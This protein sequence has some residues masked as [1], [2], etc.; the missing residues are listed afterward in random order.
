MPQHTVHICCPTPGH[1]R[2]AF[3]DDDAGAFGAERDNIADFEPGIDLIDLER[4]DAKQAFPFF[5]DQDFRWIGAASFTAQGQLRF[6]A[7]G[8]DRF[9]QGNVDRDHTPEFTILLSS[10]DV[11]PDASWFNL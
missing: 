8:T 2:F 7:G 9:V 1:D 11:D 5:F 4:I 6:Y 10:V 3:D